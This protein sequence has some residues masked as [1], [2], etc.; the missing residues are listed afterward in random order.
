[1]QALAGGSCPF[2]QGIPQSFPNFDLKEGQR[3]WGGHGLLNSRTVG[4]SGRRKVRAKPREGL[5]IPKSN[6]DYGQSS[7]YLK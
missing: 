4:S 3:H 7:F 1:M 5:L 2:G 6:A